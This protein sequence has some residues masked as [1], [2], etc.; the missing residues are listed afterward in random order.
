L[1]SLLTKNVHRTMSAMALVTKPDWRALELNFES[2]LPTASQHGCM[3][4]SGSTHVCVDR[5]DV[6][7][8]RSLHTSPAARAMSVAVVALN[9]RL[10]SQMR[11]FTK[12]GA[13]VTYDADTTFL[14]RSAKVG[15][16]K[17]V[18]IV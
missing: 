9:Q 4:D 7:I 5:K 6:S 3:T 8:E 11:K 12:Q 18:N 10:R 14:N 17:I 15:N 2:S 13:I 1:L 16:K